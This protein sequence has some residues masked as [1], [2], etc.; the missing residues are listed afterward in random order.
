MLVKS[1]VRSAVAAL[2]VI[3]LSVVM[4]AQSDLDTVTFSGKITDSQGLAVV[5]ATV[6]A[7]LV[8]TGEKHSATTNE[9]GIYRIINLRPG[10]YKV[11]A[12][13]KG[14]ET[15]ETPVFPT[16]AA[17]N[18]TRDFKLNPA[19][20]KA[21]ANV[22]VSDDDTPLVDT[23]R[24][25]VG[26]TV[27]QREIE[28]LPVDS[29]NPLDLVLTLGG[30]AEEQL[31]TRDLSED[32]GVRGVSAPGTTPEEAGIFSLSGGAAYSNNITIDGMDNNDDRGATFRFQPSMD[33]VRE[34]QVI[35]NQFSA[36]YGRASGGRV[37]ISTRGGDNRFRGRVYYYFRDESLNANTWNNNRRG[38]RKP[39]FQ[40]NDPGFTIGGPIKKNKL[41][42]FTSY[43]HDNVF[44]TTVLDAWVPLTLQNSRFALP[45]PNN[46]SAGTVTVA[47]GAACPPPTGATCPANVVIGNYL[48]PTDTP[49][50]TNIFNTRV[51]WNL[52]KS[53]NVTFM[54]Q[55][56]RLN[57][58]RAFSGTNRIA[59]SI[60]GRIRNT[61]AYNVTHNWFSGNKVNQLRAQYSKLDPSAAQNAGATAPAVLVTFTPPGA[62]SS[63]TQTLGSTLSAS[64]R[65]ENRWQ[66]QD[67]FSLVHGTQTWRAGVDYQHV[68]TTFIDRTDAS[69]T[70]SFSNYSFF[71]GNSV[72]TIRQNFGGSSSLL[73][74]Y[75]GIFVQNDWRLKPNFTLTMGLRYERESVLKD[76]NNWGPRFAF[77][78]DPFK[79]GK[80]VIRFG[81][82]IFYNRVLL[83]TVDDYT[84]DS[85]T[86]RL[87]S[88]SFNV[89]T[90]TTI[91]GPTWRAFV[92]NNFPNPF[93]L[94]TVIPINSTQS[95]T[96]RQLSR[97]AN[98]FR[99]LSPDLVIPESYQTN[100]GFEREIAKGLVF[101]ANLT[102]NKTVHLWRE[103]NPNAP[104]LPS[105]VTDVNGDGQITL[106]DFLLGVTSGTNRFYSG[107]ASDTVGQH[108]T[109]SDTGTACVA[110][111]ALCFVN[112]NSSNN[113]SASS[114]APVGTVVNTPICRAFAAVNPLRPFFSTL[115]AIQLEQVN[116]I[117]N[118]R[119]IGA[120]FE[121]RRR[122]AKLGRGFGATWRLDYTL[123]RLMDDG[124]VNTSDPTLPGNFAREWSRSLS[125]R[126]HRIGFTATLDTPRWAGKLRFSPLFRWGSSAPFNLG[127]GGVDRNLDDLSNDRP[128]YFGPSNAIDWRIYGSSFPTGLASQFAFAP[129]GS[130][131]N[132][133]RNA[134][135]G[136][137]LWQFN[138]NVTREWKLSERL[139]LRPSLEVFNPLNMRI[140]SFGS[141][142]IDFS[143]L[144]LC[145]SGGTLTTAQQDT[146]NSFLAPVRTMTGR[147]MRLGIRLDF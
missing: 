36:E 48:T 84:A 134:G 6:T 44:D 83:R 123:S 21:E 122:Y 80:G 25:V 1:L 70:Y 69:G 23:T 61:D 118:S 40:E 30:T 53:Q 113:S 38:I 106:T 68:D 15:Q 14:F 52:S 47:G 75:S 104:V 51:D 34:V 111:S 17:Q 131:G 88:S 127:N 102:Y 93:T 62:T 10:N 20:V 146:C 135:N 141:N 33:A 55:R 50:K 16:I 76:N 117:G 107:S 27:T 98:V 28:E 136:P 139:K 9:D 45:A 86:F 90:G 128:S 85:Q 39:P 5:G 126:T 43:E 65:K 132:L 129:I 130:P 96:V 54:W 13:N 78:W 18:V 3:T 147:R 143:S 92:S 26:G 108:T 49:Y 31:S 56:G 103:T 99:S 142:F 7:T 91:D 72:S 12:D 82:G 71:L 145:S 124:I 110:G 87:D 140:F 115:G 46:P 100:V 125:D 105:G 119:Y 58:L 24:T 29:R 11:T 137:Q 4:F 37:N 97:P 81:A 41:F 101:E 66:V 64:D 63:T 60:I 120:I 95:F 19:G 94:D 2:F 57:D 112:V 89:P 121:L 59:D 109:Q 138:L 77:A 32:R 73:N 74:K 42:F 22:T 144:G 133:P 114:C 79:K 116:P 35:T 67:I 8:E